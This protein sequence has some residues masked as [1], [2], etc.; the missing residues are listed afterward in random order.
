MESN[1]VQRRRD[2]WNREEFDILSQLDTPW[3][4]Q[5]Y[6]NSLEYNDAP[7][8]RSPRYVIKNQRANCAEGALF[9]AS[10]LQFHQHLPV[11][12]DLKAEE[13]E[14]DDHLLALFTQNGCYGAIAKSN[15]TTLGFRE[16]VYFPL[17]ELVMSYFDF[18]F[19]KEGKK[20][21]RAYSIPFGI[22]E[23]NHLKW[24]TSEK[25][26]DFI[27]ETMEKT[28]YHSLLSKTMIKNLSNV[29]PDLIQ[30]GLLKCNPAGLFKK[31]K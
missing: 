2:F 5:C 27:I 9:A 12:L 31:D 4:I 21:L 17:R 1:G 13:G 30:A 7:E 11:I 26:I 8:C 25:E 3:K 23:F 15:F 19:T 10:C 16:P 22:S 29:S 14:D 28:E 24:Q 6:L 18:Y 20:T